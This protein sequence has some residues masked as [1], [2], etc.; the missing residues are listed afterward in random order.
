MACLAPP[1]HRFLAGAQGGGPARARRRQF[2]LVRPERAL[3]RAPV[4]LWTM[5]GINCRRRSS[6][7]VAQQENWFA[8]GTC[9]VL[10]PKVPGKPSARASC[11]AARPRTTTHTLVGGDPVAV[12]PRAPH[13]RER[14]RRRLPVALWY[15]PPGPTADSH[16]R[17]VGPDHP[18]LSCRRQMA[19]CGSAR[20]SCGPRI[21]ARS[22]RACLP[23]PCSG[24][25]LVASWRWSM[26]SRLCAPVLTR[27]S[28]SLPTARTGYARHSLAHRTHLRHRACPGGHHG[29]RLGRDVCTGT[30]ADAGR[31]Q[32]GVTLIL[33]VV[34]T[35]TLTHTL[36]QVGAFLEY[37]TM[38]S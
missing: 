23:S 8:P 18:P 35:L 25:R 1:P 5:V 9:R 29:T 14:R 36:I 38:G 7:A 19:G 16:S 6:P 34:L 24:G 2:E 10:L 3:E 33:T 27:T 37:V 12:V 21:P 20:R 17:W 32:L 28:R 4:A 31:A 30:G 13:G 15:V 11:D 22:R 26:M